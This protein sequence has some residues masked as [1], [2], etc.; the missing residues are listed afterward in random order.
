[1]TT[2]TRKP[3]R[4]A[5]AAA[6]LTFLLPA[7]AACTSEAATP[8]STASTASAPPSPDIR[9]LR[10]PE[11]LLG[12]PKSMDRVTTGAAKQ[13]LDT[14]KR[15][16]APAT[17]A[18]GWAYGDNGPDADMVFITG[19][20]GTVT[21]QNGMVERSLQPYR[22]KT[23]KPVDPG[24]LGGTAHCGQGRTEDESYLVACAWADDQTVG[25]VAF[26][27]SRPQG[28]RT[29]QFLEVRRAMTETKA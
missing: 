21:D 20:S 10:M 5:A 9:T 29:A 4:S 19:V 6:V 28:D 14:L 8:P 23:H 22:I 11:T 26:V 1:M 12:L 27:S 7:A 24:E 15:E 17:S 13:H 3:F 18:V 2:S 25:I 16:V